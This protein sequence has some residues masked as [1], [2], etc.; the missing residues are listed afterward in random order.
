[1]VKQSILTLALLL[2]LSLGAAAQTPANNQHHCGGGHACGHACGKQNATTH[3]CAHQEAEEEAPEL[4]VF[5]SVETAPL[6][7]GG[8]QAMYRYI[9]QNLTYPEKAKEKGIS[10]TAMITFVVEKD[11][12]ISNVRI[13]RD[14]GAGLGAA[15]AAVVQ[16][17]PR[18]TPG[19]QDGKPVRTQFNLPVQFRLK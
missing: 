12:S 4:K 9:S 19:K 11:G 13:L 2:T 5:T 16:G 1:M 8:E 15:A 6:F 18:W 3:Q 10:G 17:M 7:P 14:P